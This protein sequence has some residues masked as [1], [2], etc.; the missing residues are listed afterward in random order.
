[1]QIRWRPPNPL[2]S[3]ADAFGFLLWFVGAVAV[4]VVDRAD[5]P[6]ALSAGVRRESRLSQRACDHGA[7][8]DAAVPFLLA[9]RAA[10]R[11]SASR[12]WCV[13]S[14]DPVLD[15]RARTLAARA[16][17][18]PALAAGVLRGRPGRARR[19]PLSPPVDT[20]SEQLLVAHMAEHLLIGDIA[21]LLLVLGMTG[22]LLAPLLR[23]PVD[24]QAA[25]ADPSGGGDR[26][27][28]GQLLRLA[29]AATCTRR[30]CATTRCTRW[31]TPP[32]WRSASRCGWRCWGR[33]PK[34]AWFNN[35][36]R[37]V[38]IIVVRLVGTVLANVLIFGGTV[39]Y[40]YYRP[41]TPTGTSARSPTRSPPAG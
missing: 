30:R 21:A 39:F 10:S 11:R 5:H 19:S 12:S 18:G 1:M 36:A 15:L 16:P 7:A 28:G 6:G 32:S 33:C 20:L 3:E 34:P 40:P 29:L 4:I 9:D 17:P 22:P 38:Y 13:L 24:R 2:R 25:G 26:R 27:L 41:A 37:L 14:L 8:A 31:S 23:N 35:G